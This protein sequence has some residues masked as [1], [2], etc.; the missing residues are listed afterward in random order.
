MSIP[1]LSSANFINILQVLGRFWYC[2][3]KQYKLDTKNPI[4]NNP[5][6][7]LFRCIA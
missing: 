4:I 3:P 6:E 7:K 1:N 2:L 5:Y